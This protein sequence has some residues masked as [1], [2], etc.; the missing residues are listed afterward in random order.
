MAITQVG[1]AAK[2]T[3]SRTPHYFGA[4]LCKTVGY[5]CLKVKRGQ[6]WKKLFPDE[7]QRDIVQRVNR[8][9]M[10][11][12][13][14]RMIAVPTNLAKTTIQDV[15]PFPKQI[16]ASDNKLIIVD[17]NKLAWGAYGRDG[18]LVKWGAISSGK[19]YCGDIKRACTTMTGEFYVF[20][21]K[22]KRCKSSIFPVGR[23][24]SV[25]P[26]CM[27]FYKGYALHGSNEVP[28]YRASHGCV[29][30]FTRDAKWLN[31]KF[32]EL[33]NREGTL[34]GTKVVVQKLTSMD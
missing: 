14:G 8:T 34:I 15:A 16:E 6:S 2:K 12:W 33:P 17:Q 20:N 26:Y 7:A 23:G 21:K 22:D 9:N 18:N 25:M 31:T 19:N 28:G 11:L 4:A 24:G 3:T 13:A 29:R 27:Y 32:V 30:L 1:L 10:R 5:E